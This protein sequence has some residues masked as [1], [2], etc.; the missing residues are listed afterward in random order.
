M[1]QSNAEMHPETNLSVVSNDYNNDFFDRMAS[2][3]DEK[4]IPTEAEYLEFEE[5]EIHNLIF[6]GFQE[7]TFGEDIKEAVVFQGRDGWRFINANSV[8]VNAM[9]RLVAPAPVRITCVGEKKNAK[10]NKYKDFKIF[11]L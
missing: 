5:G 8:I 4:M 10:G 1:K 3:E 6:T 11:T 2:L 7:C 9:K